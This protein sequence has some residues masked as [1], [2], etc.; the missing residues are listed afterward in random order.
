MYGAS[1]CLEWLGAIEWEREAELGSAAG[2]CW[3]ECEFATKLASECVAKGEAEAKA[4]DGAVG[5]L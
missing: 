2:W 1:L 5:L 4:C 3:E